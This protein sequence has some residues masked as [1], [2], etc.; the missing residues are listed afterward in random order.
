V[1]ALVDEMKWNLIS[2]L[3]AQKFAEGNK[4]NKET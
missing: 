3:L 2:D 4:H 1:D